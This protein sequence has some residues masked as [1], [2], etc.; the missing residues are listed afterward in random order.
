MEAQPLKSENVESPDSKS[1][2]KHWRII[3][4][5]SLVFFGA[6][7]FFMN[8]F[9]N[10]DNIIVKFIE[11]ELIEKNLEDPFV[12][13]DFFM[14]MGSIRVFTPLDGYDFAYKSSA[15]PYDVI[16]LKSEQTFRMKEFI[17]R[18]TSPY[19]LITHN[20]SLI[21]PGDNQFILE[22]P[23][24]VHWF[25]SNLN[26]SHEK[27]SA[28][29]YGVSTPTGLQENLKQLSL[30]QKKDEN[31]EKILELMGDSKFFLSAEKEEVDTCTNWEAIVM[32]AVPIVK[33]G[34]NNEL[35]D[36]ERVLML[37]SYNERA[38]CQ[39]DASPFVRSIDHRK[40][41]WRSLLAAS[42]PGVPACLVELAAFSFEMTFAQAWA[43]LTR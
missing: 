27:L 28:L 14:D 11:E 15:G 3:A 20:S 19:F 17:K 36:G 25:T 1:L 4:L 18:N 39:K 22:D 30:K 9:T 40:R 16:S 10:T 43:I 12:S 5:C 6:A 31:K 21:M 42:H 38:N 23:S 29:P 2:W 32:G 35:Y 24:L 41:A 34:S 8:S 26:I 7:C 33:N 13:Q 37:E